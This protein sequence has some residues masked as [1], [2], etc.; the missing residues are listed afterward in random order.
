M[1]TKRFSPIFIIHLFI[2][3]AGSSLYGQQQSGR[4]YE[5][6]NLPATARITALGGYAVPGIES[7]LGM[8]LY[9]PSLL[10]N[11]PTSQL[12]LNMVDYFS[13]ISYG[14]AGANYRFDRLGNISFSV[15]YISYGSFIEADEFGNQL[16]NFGAGEYAAMIGWGRSLTEK[17]SIGSNIKLISSGMEGYSSLGL[18][19]DIAVSWLDRE[20][21]IAA[22]LVFRNIG[23]QITQ[24]HSSQP[25]MLPF[26]ISL[27]VSKKLINA[28]LRFS[29]V[30]HNLH[31]F[32][33][34]YE[35]FTEPQDM[36]FI[37]EEESA[38]SRE[39]FDDL[40]DKLL[41]HTV[42][43]VEFT[44]TKAFSI[45][46]GYNYRRR[47][48]LKADTRPAS[49]GLSFGAGFRVSAFQIYYGRANYHL[50]GAPNHFSL[51]A[52]LGYFFKGNQ[53]KPSV[54]WR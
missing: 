27:G 39:F 13:D 43:G 40:G 17:L 50:A 42:F 28:P 5:F 7:D 3:L 54:Y 35:S 25:E 33:L 23:R 29:M 52:D 49:V 24:Y 38:G 45:G 14:T 6:L 44:P 26:D 10:S 53:S 9:Y 34:T 37:N 51:L 18:A 19:T 12:T 41:R 2:I 21:M 36:F 8:A 15:Q 11:T 16:G 31:R 4:V 46:I 48:E 30:A 47:Q 20:R 22:S 1:Q 32:D